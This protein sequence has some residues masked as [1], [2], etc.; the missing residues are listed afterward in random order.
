MNQEE[1]K[2]LND[3]KKLIKKGKRKFKYRKDRDYLKDLTEIGLEE[4]DAWNH[5]LWLN[6]NFFVTDNKPK[7]HKEGK[8]LIFKKIINNYLVYIKLKLEIN[9]Q[10]DETVCWS[11]HRDWS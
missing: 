11:F 9:E 1:I 7:F 6:E 4:K 3:M 10:G 2:L 5:I 8:S